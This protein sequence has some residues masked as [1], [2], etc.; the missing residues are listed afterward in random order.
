MKEGMWWSSLEEAKRQFGV[1]LR[2]AKRVAIPERNKD[3]SSKYR[4]IHGGTDGIELNIKIKVR[5]G[6]Q[7]P[8]APG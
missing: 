4:T 7:F 5:D 8:I 3:G 6:G 2:N 1:R